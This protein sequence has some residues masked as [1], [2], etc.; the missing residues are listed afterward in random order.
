MLYTGNLRVGLIGG[1]T[2]FEEYI[3]QNNS[4]VVNITINYSVKI[5]ISE[6]QSLNNS[7]LIINNQLNINKLVFL[8]DL[9]FSDHR[10]DYV[11][12]IIYYFSVTN[13]INLSGL[14][15]E[16]ETFNF[17]G[18]GLGVSSTI[19]VSLLASLYKYFDISIDNLSLAKE[20]YKLERNILNIPGGKQDFYPSLYNGFNSIL[21][22]KSNT[23]IKNIKVHEK[24]KNFMDTKI[25]LFKL[26]NIRDSDYVIMDQLFN[27]SIKNEEMIS[28]Y[29]KM[30]ELTKLF[31][32]YSESGDV[33]NFVKTFNHGSVLK[34]SFSN[35]IIPK[36]LT[37]L[38]ASFKSKTIIGWKVTGA[39]GGGC[40]LL[41]V[42]Q[43]NQFEVITKF[44]DN[45]IKLL[46]LSFKW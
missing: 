18:S 25:L 39:G 40:I 1:G 30:Y 38:L 45:D 11:I 34:N 6:Y 35:L 43:V 22:N 7:I 44:Y 20:A 36:Y 46:P 28:K 16:I 10:D 9:K 27:Y 17:I 32:K 5:K 31:I 41:M 2:D 29:K 14:I 24:I 13:N 19:C 4:L 8:G 23:I 15:F 33:N 37:D 12:S 42:N 3:N 26:P 21:F